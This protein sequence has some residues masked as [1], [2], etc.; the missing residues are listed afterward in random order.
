MTEE[1][2]F[3]DDMPTAIEPEGNSGDYVMLAYNKA[4]GVGV[5][6]LIEEPLKAPRRTCAPWRQTASLTGPTTVNSS[7]CSTRTVHLFTF[8]TR[9]GSTQ[10]TPS[11]HRAS[12][13]AFLCGTSISKSTSSFPSTTSPFNISVSYGTN[14]AESPERSR[15]R[16]LELNQA[17]LFLGGTPFGP[18]W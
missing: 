4:L 15:E 9:S 16:M 6:Q 2:G 3:A 1:G 7:T 17:T 10:T 11:E 14:A 18:G 13:S 8:Y 5:E 12:S